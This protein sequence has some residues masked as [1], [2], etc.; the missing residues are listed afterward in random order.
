[1]T[2]MGKIILTGTHHKRN[3]VDA[4]FERQNARAAPHRH[5][6]TGCACAA[7]TPRR[8]Q[9]WQLWQTNSRA[10]GPSSGITELIGSMVWNCQRKSTDSV[11]YSEGQQLIKDLQLLLAFSLIS[12]VRVAWWLRICRCW[13]GRSTPN[14]IQYIPTENKS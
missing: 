1:M 6:G 12:A 3:R 14:K 9:H 7:D 2:Q 11:H 8:P 5:G 4:S 13:T 10:T